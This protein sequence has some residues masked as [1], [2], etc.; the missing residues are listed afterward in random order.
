MCDRNHQMMDGHDLWRDTMLVSAADH[1][2]TGSTELMAKMPVITGGNNPLFGTRA[3]KGGNVTV[4]MMTDQRS[5][6]VSNCSVAGPTAGENATALA[7]ALTTLLGNDNV[8]D[9]HIF[10]LRALNRR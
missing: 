10:S 8:T 4:Q 1:G 7:K 5:G 6:V 2:S 3:A 9:G